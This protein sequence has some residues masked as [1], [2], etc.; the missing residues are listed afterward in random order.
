MRR[1]QL[2]AAITF[3]VALLLTPGVAAGHGALRRSEPAAGARLG[4]AP[5]VLRLTFTERPEIQFTRVELLG[6]DSA[7]IAL[8]PLALESARTVRAE[9]RGALVRAG[10]YTVVWQMAGADGHPVRGRFSFTIA[11]GASG[12]ASEQPRGEPAAVSVTPPGQ[13]ATPQATAHHDPV[14]M[15]DAGEGF[16]AESPLYV[17]VRWLGYSALLVVLGAV[18]FRWVVL[19]ILRR[20]APS[21][22][23]A[24]LVPFA[25]RRAASLGL[26]AAVAL[27]LAALMRLL[28]QSYA[29]HGS[30]DALNG[31]LVGAMVARTVW[32]TGWL[33]QVAGVVVA[34]GGFL[35]ARR[36]RAFGWVLAALGAVT[37]AFSA[38]LSGHAASSPRLAGLAVLAD[39]LHVLGAG[40][41][42]GSLFVVIGAGVPAALAVAGRAEERGPAV[43]DLVNAFSPTALAF[44]GVVAVTGLFAGWLHLGSLPA[45]WQSAYGRTLLVKL[46]VLSVVAG[47]GAYNW[48]RARPA[49]G[50]VDGA[51]RI[52]RSA[53]LE[54]AVGAVVLV[55]TAVLV[56]T[57]TPMDVTAMTQ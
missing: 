13:A 37:L 2:Y 42:L 41:W 49:L 47:T 17:A 43:A 30:A 3:A 52:R 28:A 32:G 15:P 36:D 4:A 12:L 14:S 20:R 46:A 1:R 29:M 22:R 6:P 27:G 5:R 39:A 48:L 31:G 55:I 26:A 23:S 56:A 53:S 21:E 38:A 44:A 8:G 57:P 25:S 10:K 40:G 9:V 35:A 50:D 19:A 16:G 33:L 54:L 51:R 18:S 24:A 11:P 7:A 34:L 45:L